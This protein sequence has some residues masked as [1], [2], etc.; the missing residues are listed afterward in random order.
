MKSNRLL[1]V[2]TIIAVF[3][4]GISTASAVESPEKAQVW[5]FRALLGDKPIGS[6]RFEVSRKQGEIR[7]HSRAEFK[8]TFL[9]IPVYSY[10]HEAHEQWRNGCLVNVDSNTDDNGDQFTIHSKLD[11][12]EFTITTLEKSI[13]LSGCVHSF[14]YWDIGLLKSDRLLNVQTGEYQAVKLRDL[15]KVEFSI[16]NKVIEA[17]KYRL[18]AENVKIDLWYTLDEHWIA[19][20]STTASGD[21]VRYLPESGSFITA[22]EKL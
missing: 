11:N 1:I 18:T 15:G 13:T 22:G 14:A 19:L 21:I 7:V 12:T 3:G 10:L 5:N 16:G 6:H 8:V 4:A 9:M 20:E 17:H 2:A